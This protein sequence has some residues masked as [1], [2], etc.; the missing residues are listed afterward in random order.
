MAWWVGWWKPTV[1][2]SDQ[3]LAHGVTPFFATASDNYDPRVQGKEVADN[4]RVCNNSSLQTPYNR[5]VSQTSQA[6]ELCILWPLSVR[7]GFA[8]E[9]RR[10]G[11]LR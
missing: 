11:L 5:P 8:L 1:P 10:T 2:V 6:S 9:I 4:V 3:R 7:M